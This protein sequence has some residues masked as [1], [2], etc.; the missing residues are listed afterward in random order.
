MADRYEVS[1]K[2]VSQEGTCT[3]GHKVGD[4]WVI[5]RKTPA[6]MCLPAFNA[7]YQFARVLQYGGTFPFGPDPD[8]VANVY[9]PDRKNPVSFEVRR[10]RE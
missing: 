1:V 10:L 8:V 9:C 4:E 3:A 2:V 7:V 5:G 6:G